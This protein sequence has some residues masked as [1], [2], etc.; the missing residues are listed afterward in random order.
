MARRVCR[1]TTS[2]MARTSTCPALMRRCPVRD[3]LDELS[4]RW[5]EGDAVGLATVAAMWQSAPRQPGAAMLVEPGGQ[6]SCSV[7]GGCVES[8]VYELAAQIVADPNQ[9]PVLQRYGVSDETAFSVGLT[10]GGIIDVFVERV[11]R[12]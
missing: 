9:P 5:D 12:S 2:P 4:A 7:S 11:S 10:C 6:A 3:V 1:A 8:A